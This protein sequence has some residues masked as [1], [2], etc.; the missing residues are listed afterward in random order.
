MSITALASIV[1]WLVTVGL[2]SAGSLLA[3]E[4]SSSSMG[5]RSRPP[6]SSAR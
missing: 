5:K 1:G 4:V 2:E 3:L 6:A